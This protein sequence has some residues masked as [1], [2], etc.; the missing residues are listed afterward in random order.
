MNDWAKLANFILMLACV[1][2]ILMV[3]LGI[4]A[5]LVGLGI[6]DPITIN[7]RIALKLFELIKAILLIH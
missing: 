5:A 4:F 3:I 1:L 2:I 7:S 6:M